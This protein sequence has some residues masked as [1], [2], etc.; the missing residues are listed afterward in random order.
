MGGD[1]DG[2]TLTV[3]P[4][5]NITDILAFRGNSDDG[6]AVLKLNKTIITDVTVFYGG[7]GRGET[8][9]DVERNNCGQP[10]VASIWNG[11]ISNSWD[12]PNN[13]DCGNIPTVGSNV[14]IPSGLSLYPT[15]YIHTEIKSLTLLPGSAV[16][17]L[18][19][20]ILKL[21]GQ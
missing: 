3:L 9:V 10:G 2:F 15:V 19:G 14:L 16:T 5:A 21:N 8:M 4:R 11:S 7:N 20:V 6:F 13:W 17:I 18:P 12:N 1:D